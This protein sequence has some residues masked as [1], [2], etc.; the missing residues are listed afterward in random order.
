[1]GPISVM[2]VDD[3]KTFL[4]V[5]AEFLEAQGDVRVIYST[6]DGRDA[7]ARVPALRPQV[8]L[9]DLAMPGM[10]GL[11][12]IPRLRDCSPEVGIVA[13][14]VMDSH[15]FQNAAISAGANAFVSKA[16]V[17]TE[18]MPAIRQLVNGSQ[19]EEKLP[20]DSAQSKETPAN[21]SQTTESPTARRVMVMDDDAH[22]RQI[23]SR[24]LEAAGYAVYPA[25]TIQEARDLL[26]RL[27]FDVL[28]C[29][30]HMGHER[31]TDIL[32]E[33]SQELFTS[34]AQ[35]IMV[36]GQ[37]RYRDICEEMGADFFL[38]KPVALGALVAMVNRLTTRHSSLGAA[39]A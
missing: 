1:M 12:F 2:L 21:P 24:A 23:Y 33:Y 27:R 22:L 15:Y 26:G 30:I 16:R 28:L 38:E 17:R 31:G 14:S 4:R 32:Q 36:S 10:H 34:G 35:V 13:L 11:E 37:A 7:L 19:A 5:M 9:A 3:N 39:A 8:V 20:G 18:L 29:D 25:G 6:S